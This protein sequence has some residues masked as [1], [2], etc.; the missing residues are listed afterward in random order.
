MREMAR[1]RAGDKTFFFVFLFTPF[2]RA[3]L[4]AINFLVALFWAGVL[5][6]ARVFFLAAILS[7]RFQHAEN[8]WTEYQQNPTNNNPPEIHA[9]KTNNFAAGFI[10]YGGGLFW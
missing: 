7:T 5:A 1:L 8:C 10:N 2:R 4:K 3:L 9:Q 6:L